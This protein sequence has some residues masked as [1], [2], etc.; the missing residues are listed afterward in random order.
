MLK[1]LF[2]MFYIPVA[3]CSAITPIIVLSPN[4]QD[5]GIILTNDTNMPQNYLLSV[6]ETSF[7][8]KDTQVITKDSHHLKLSQGMLYLSPGKK[9]KIQFHYNGSRGN[10]KYFLVKAQEK[11]SKK[12]QVYATAVASRVIIRPSKPLFKYRFDGKS[13]K[14]ESNGYIMLM[15][16]EQCGKVQKLTKLVKPGDSFQLPTISADMLVSIEFNRHIK[17]LVNLCKK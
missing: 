4:E 13:L 14:N 11:V 7:P 9:Q 12:N 8:D 15:I 17:Q 5:G 2:L 1:Y 16:D 3:Y 10:E 6:D